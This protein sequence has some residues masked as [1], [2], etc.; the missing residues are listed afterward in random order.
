MTSE[1]SK[2]IRV[3]I[4]AI[5]GILLLIIGILLGK[6]V[7]VTSNQTKISLRFPNSGGI[8]AESPIH[9]NGVERG[10]VTKVAN[11]NGSVLVTGTL[12]VS[13]DIME[14]AIGK[15]MLLE[16]TGGKKIEITPGKSAYKFDFSKEMRGITTTDISDLVALFGDIGI[17]AVM[18]VKRLDTIAISLTEILSDEQFIRDVKDIAHNA[19]SMIENANSLLDENYAAINQSIQNIKV[20]TTDLRKAVEKHEPTVGKIINELQITVTELREFL[21][22]GDRLADNA[23][24]LVDDFVEITNNI[25]S[26]DGLVNKLIY[27]KAFF[28]KLDSAISSLSELITFINVNG[29]NVNMRLGT[30][31]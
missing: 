30:R 24:K 14:D 12:A 8:T 9:V 22:K 4:V 13:D 20:L 6:G 10:E 29:I 28:M 31:P 25:K 11:D 16:V 17:D 5:S 26:G 3:G 19:S 15:I 27:D 23:N 7:D 18:M 1:R 21:S 2:E